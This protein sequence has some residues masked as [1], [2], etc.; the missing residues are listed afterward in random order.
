MSKEDEAW[1]LGHTP[2]YLFNNLTTVTDHSVCTLA[3]L[4][5]NLP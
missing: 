1:A 3:Q 4:M 5:Q 2:S